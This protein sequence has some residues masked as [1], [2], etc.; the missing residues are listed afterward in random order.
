MSRIPN[1]VPLCSGDHITSGLRRFSERK[2]YT[3][4]GELAVEV[5]GNKKQEKQCCLM[6]KLD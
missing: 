4:Y 3:R 6:D 2:R 1:L 5:L